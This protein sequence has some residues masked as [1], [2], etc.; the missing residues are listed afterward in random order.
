MVRLTMP[1]LHSNVACLSARHSS[2]SSFVCSFRHSDGKWPCLTTQSELSRHSLSAEMRCWQDEDMAGAGQAGA[3][4][5][6]Q[7]RA[8][9]RRSLPDIMLPPAVR[10]LVRTSPSVARVAD[11]AVLSVTGS[12]AGDFLNGIVSSSTAASATHLPAHFYTAF[13]H[14]QASPRLFLPPILGRSNCAEG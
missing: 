6:A 2:G 10:S 1:L 9:G 5:V 14:A 8:R 4:S 7:T 3:R 13:L 11:R 12:Q